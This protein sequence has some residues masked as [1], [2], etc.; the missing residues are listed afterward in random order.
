MRKRIL[1][2]AACALL[3]RAQQFDV[4]T[5]KPAEPITPQMIAAG[6]L[7]VGQ[8]ITGNQV[9]FG[10]MALRDLAALAF[11]VKPLQITGP[12]WVTQQRYDITALMP[13]GADPKQI[14]A[15]LQAL[16]KERFKLAA[17]KTNDEQQVYG[18]EV[19]RGGHKMKVSE[20]PVPEPAADAAPKRGEQVIEAGGQQI[21]MSQTPVAGGGANVSVSVGGM[22]QRMSMTPDGRMHMEID[23][24]TMAQLAETLT[25]MMDL[26]VVDK[27]G[28][29][30]QFQVV[31]DLSMADILQIA[32]RA[33]MGANL[34][35][36]L[37]GGAPGGPAGLNAADPGGDIIAAVQKLGLRLEK[38][39][40]PVETLVIESAERNPTEN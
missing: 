15:M 38:Q 11:E 10:Y 20:P 18:L 25:P 31:L 19:A 1:M 17:R 34:P 28:L 37:P 23:R 4:A 8:K 14:P 22:T 16:L 24:L 2:L 32:R 7:N 6:K 21:R 36:T 27:T 39:K 26:P 13:E 3:A 12:D 5:I 9:S 33:G 40:A 35:A 30:E 29:T